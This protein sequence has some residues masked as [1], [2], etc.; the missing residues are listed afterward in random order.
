MG[1][2]MFMKKN[3][4]TLKKDFFGIIV[5]LLLLICVGCDGNKDSKDE[6]KLATPVI[7]QIYNKADGVDLSWDEVEGADNYRVFKKTEQSDWEIVGDTDQNSY[8]DTSV[9]KGEI[10]T[11]SVRCIDEEGG[12]YLSDYS[13]EGKKIRYNYLDSPVLKSAEQTNEGVEIKWDS[14]D[15]ADCYRVY[16]QKPEGGWEKLADVQQLNYIDKNVVEFEEYTYTV[17]CVDSETASF[18]SAYDKKGISIVYGYCNQPVLKGLS[19]SNNGIEITWEAV[20]GAE[21]YRVFRKTEGGKWERVADVKGTECI[22]DGVEKGKTYFYTLRCLSSD[23]K[24]YISDYDK[25]GVSITYN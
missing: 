18:I 7:S 25:N 19:V 17:R 10:Y 2:R 15:G 5:F 14:V 24:S 6:Y 3:I 20:D 1:V 11:Y 16:R 4:N 13:E 12:K 21:Q 9:V 23:G 22:D 8:L